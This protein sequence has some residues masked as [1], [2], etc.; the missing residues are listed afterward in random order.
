MG[1]LLHGSARTTEAVR[2]ASPQSQE[3]IGVLAER[4]GITPKAVAKWQKRPCVHDAPRGPTDVRSTSFNPAEAAMVVAFRKPT[5]WPR[6]ACLSALPPSRPHP[7]RSSPHRGWQRHHLSRLPETTGD[8]PKK[9]SKPYPSGYCHI[10]RAEGRTAGGKLSLFV[11][12]DRTSEV[13]DAEFQD[14][15]T[16]TIA[17]DSLRHRMDAVPYQSPTVLPEKGIPFTNP[18]RH[19]EAFQPI[20]DRVCHEPGI[21]PRLTPPNH[22]WTNGQ[23]ERGNRTLKD[24]TVRRESYQ[25]HEP[26]KAPLQP[27]LMADSFARRLKTLKGL[28]PDED[29][30][31]LWTKDPA[32]FHCDP[33]QHTV[34]LNT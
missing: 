23:G 27:C 25:A 3:S 17:A 20:V 22:P 6:E 26:L 30:C 33:C 34:G 24:A 1:Q 8:K 9:Q 18:A 16:T 13:A 21:A 7:T 12:I 19:Q 28:T 14:S 31:P 4:Y 2:R 11:A 29:L 15:R 32:R 10:D 5:L